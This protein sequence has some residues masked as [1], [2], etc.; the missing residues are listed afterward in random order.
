MADPLYLSIKIFYPNVSDIA[1]SQTTAGR[2][3]KMTG[4]RKK[5]FVIAVSTKNKIMH[6]SKHAREVDE[7]II[8]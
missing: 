2:K 5:A 6:E 8:F 3:Q 7:T 1:R 4:K